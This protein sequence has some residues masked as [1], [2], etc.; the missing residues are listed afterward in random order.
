MSARWGVYELHGVEASYAKLEEALLD[1]KLIYIDC[2]VYFRPEERD[3]R[4]ALIK[5]ARALGGSVTTKL[6]VANYVCVDLERSVLDEAVRTAE[7]HA[8]IVLREFIEVMSNRVAPLFPTATPPARRSSKNSVC[9]APT[10]LS[11]PFLLSH[12]AATPPH[13]IAQPSRPEDADDEKEINDD[14]LCDDAPEPLVYPKSSQNRLSLKIHATPAAVSQ[15]SQ[16][17]LVGDS[18]EP[19]E[20]TEDELE[21]HDC[22]SPCP[23][24]EFLVPD[25]QHSFQYVHIRE[26]AADFVNWVAT[27][28]RSREQARPL[29]PADDPDDIVLSTR[30]LMETGKMLASI[31]PEALS[32]SSLRSAYDS[33]ESY[34]HELEDEAHKGWKHREQLEIEPL[35]PAALDC[36]LRQARHCYV[37]ACPDMCELDSSEDRDKKE[38]AASADHEPESEDSDHSPPVPPLRHNTR[39][40]A[41]ATVPSVTTN[42][43]ATT[44]A[45]QNKKRGRVV[46]E[47][48]AEQQPSRA[49]R[50]RK[51]K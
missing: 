15:T 36:Y 28:A 1:D 34:K 18:E 17:I 8:E 48:S 43:N 13:A 6:S 41:T 31:V 33:R 42:N 25:N 16:P 9:P 12:H 29:N 51:T 38:C 26:W 37:E 10:P 7:A 2:C 19:V 27:Y 49:K 50:T 24:P 30:F 22:A 47:T 46:S 40:E 23:I 45:P 32:N 4:L 11:L 5:K 14:L 21:P 39:S 35:N 44:T 20:Q 3:Q